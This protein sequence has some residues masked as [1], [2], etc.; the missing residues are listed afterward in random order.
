MLLTTWR[1]SK[2]QKKYFQHEIIPSRASLPKGRQTDL[3]IVRTY[4]QI[5]YMK[6]YGPRKSPARRMVHPGNLEGCDQPTWA[7]RFLTSMNS[8]TSPIVC[9][10]F[11][12]YSYFIYRLVPM[13]IN[14]LSLQRHLHL[15][16]SLEELEEKMNYVIFR[17]RTYVRPG[18]RSRGNE[19]ERF[20]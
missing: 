6:S 12:R 8:G 7:T 9:M 17:S 20:C 4:W 18:D 16:L 2:L 14:F 19:T 5:A 15:G 11:N 13:K 1:C 10:C 3:F